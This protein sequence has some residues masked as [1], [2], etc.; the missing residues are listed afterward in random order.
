MINW[1]NYK[2][3]Q[4]LNL[5]IS[6]TNSVADL[7]VKISDFEWA[8]N[9][10]LH[11]TDVEVIESNVDDYNKGDLLRLPLVVKDETFQFLV[12]THNIHYKEIVKE[13]QMSLN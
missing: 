13:G 9:R 10:T 4:E 5:K 3:G 6:A 1:D 8:P 11:L 7:K 2:I 12:V